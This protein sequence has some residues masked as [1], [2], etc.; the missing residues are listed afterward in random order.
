MKEE[1]S[2]FWRQ[3]SAF[4]QAVT[5]DDI[6]IVKQLD[7]SLNKT[8]DLIVTRPAVTVENIVL[9]FKFATDLLNVEA[10]DISCVK[11][12]IGLIRSLIEKY[13]GLGITLQD[14]EGIERKSAAL[15]FMVFDELRYDDQ[16]LPTIL[17]KEDYT[18]G[19][20]NPAYE[21]VRA[22]GTYPKLGA[23]I[24]DLFGLG[25]FR[26]GLKDKID[27]A[28]AGEVTRFTY[29]EECDGKSYVWINDITR[30]FSPSGMLLG[31]LI[32]INKIADRR[33]GR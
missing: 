4:K 9:Q 1:I 24:A 29:V 7:A 11:K 26:N 18:L 8:M 5:N 13:V 30:V 28:L 27:Q 12:N 21:M 20:F 17:V 15:P 10:E 19:Y 16:P 33:S 32:Q 22:E 6:D 25:H 3:Y 2:A 23:H 14:D 31:A